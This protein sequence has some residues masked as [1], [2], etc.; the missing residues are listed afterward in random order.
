MVCTEK[1]EIELLGLHRG[2]R[3]R[4]TGSAQKKDEL[5][6]LG[7]HGRGGRNRIAGSAQRRTN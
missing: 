3:N 5:E 6:L 1:D 7:L 2:G 4:I